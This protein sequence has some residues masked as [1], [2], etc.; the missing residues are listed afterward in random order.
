MPDTPAYIDL[1]CNGYHGI[2]LNK[3]DLTVDELH[4][5]CRMM[6]EQ[7]V[8]HVLGTVITEHVETMCHRLANLV[9]LR[10]SDPLA[11]ELIAGL[12][13]E[14]PFVSAEDGYRG[15]HPADAVQ[16][17]DPDTMRKLLD[18]AGGLTRIVTLAPEQD[19]GCKTIKYLADQ[20][21][22]VSAGHTNASLDKL[23]AA[24]DAGLSLFTHLGN[25]CLMHMHRHD[26]IIQRAL[27]LRNRIRPCFI[28]DGAHVS[29]FALRNYLDIVGPDRAIIVTDAMA[30]AGMP[31]GRYTIGRWDLV[32]GEDM[33]A[34]APDGSHLVGA[35]ITMAESARNLKDQLGCTDDE[36]RRMTHD[37]PLQVLNA[38]QP[39]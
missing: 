39:V 15:A 37:N 24:A 3:D 29:F 18:A 27:H 19:A 23:R 7:G 17:A 36:V 35:A 30:A 4:T 13:I 22:T 11:Q 33:V 12:H 9:K 34:R 21:I 38:A 8:Q 25:G 2:D 26:N 28:A 6:R 1:Q 5:F 32:I 31:P 10:E 14:G 16:P 20:G